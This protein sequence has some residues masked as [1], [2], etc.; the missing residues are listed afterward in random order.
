MRGGMGRWPGQDD[1]WDPGL[2]KFQMFIWTRD[3][4]RPVSG[5]RDP[6]LCNRDPASTGTFSSM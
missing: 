5:K 2:Y 4:F 3:V 1:E 6:G